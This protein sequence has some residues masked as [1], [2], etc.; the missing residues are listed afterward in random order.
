MPDRI[1]SHNISIIPEDL[2]LGAGPV[3]L[4]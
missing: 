2:Y 4:V 3:F 1:K